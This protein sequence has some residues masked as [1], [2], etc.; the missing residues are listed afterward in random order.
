MKRWLGVLVALMLVA[1]ACGGSE[2]AAVSTSDCGPGDTDGDLSFYNWAEYIDPDL[3]DAFEAEY[4]ISVEYTEYESNE[5][6]LAQVEA[7][8]AVY[9]LVV[10]SDY[11]VDTMIQE[12]LLVKLNKDAIPNLGNLDDAF[13]NLPFDEA[14]DFS[15]PYQWGTTGI[16]VN[17]G[18]IGEGFDPSWALLFDADVAD[19]YQG[20]ISLLDDPLEAMVAALHYAG[21]TLEE[22]IADNNLDAIAEAE[23]ILAEANARVAKYDSVNFGD[24]LVTGEVDIAHGWSGGFFASFAE[25]DNADELVYIIPKEGGVR[26]V[27]NMA[28]P[29]TAEHPCS[30]ST[31]INFILDAENGAT[32]T[33]W[34]YYGSPNEASEAF[35]LPEILEDE[36]IYPSGDALENLEFIPQVGELGLELQDAFT[37]SKS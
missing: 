37:R 18:A 31:M 3:I 20:R 17:V 32:L 7:G 27:D 24:D 2:E 22:V 15:V 34:N 16:G 25:A 8:A 36:A 4:G 28:I 5:E 10:P 14:G 6:M 23:A 12:D 35:I 21:Y 30:A 19:Q 1:A 13:T 11:M 26:W 33:N 29:V 9:D